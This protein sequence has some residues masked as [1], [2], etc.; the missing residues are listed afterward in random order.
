MRCLV[1]LKINNYLEIVVNFEHIADI[2]FQRVYYIPIIIKYVS[3]ELFFYIQ[4]DSCV[5]FP[6][7]IYFYDI[8]Y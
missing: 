8:Q 3:L 7:T 6:T 2:C 1:K 5:I 4:V